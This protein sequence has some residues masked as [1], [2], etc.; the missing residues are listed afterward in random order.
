MHVVYALYFLSF[1]MWFHTVGGQHYDIKEKKTDYF[2]TLFKPCEF[3]HMTSTPTKPTYPLAYAQKTMCIMISSSSCFSRLN[4]HVLCASSAICVNYI[5][6]AHERFM[7]DFVLV[8]I[9][10]GLHWVH[11]HVLC[12]CVFICAFRVMCVLFMYVYICFLIYVLSYVRMCRVAMCDMHI[13]MHVCVKVKK[14]IKKVFCSFAGGE[15]RKHS[16]QRTHMQ[17]R[18]RT[19]RRRWWLASMKQSLMIS[20]SNNSKMMSSSSLEANL[21]PAIAVSEAEREGPPIYLQQAWRRRHL[22][23]QHR[24]RCNDVVDVYGGGSIGDDGGGG[25]SLSF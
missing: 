16:S 7:C 5:V 1:F 20:S 4:S 18:G 10:L 19:G 22:D 24:Q 13:R 17:K 23:Q 9:L 21:D 12:V 3:N 25:S 8:C 15:E 2:S 11:M 6:C 14:R